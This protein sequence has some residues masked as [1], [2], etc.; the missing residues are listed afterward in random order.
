MKLSNILKE[1]IKETITFDIKNGKDLKDWL[2]NK[3]TEKLGEK[4][5]DF[6]VGNIWFISVNNEDKE[7]V[8]INDDLSVS[9]Y[10]RYVL[11]DKIKNM[12]VMRADN[13]KKLKLL[14]DKAV[15]QKEHYKFM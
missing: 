8:K 6:F 15:N 7:Y 2:N 10:K 13:N 12:E 5:K 11:D 4:V 3:I 1:I 9:I 14:L